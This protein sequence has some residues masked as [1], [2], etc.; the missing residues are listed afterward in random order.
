MGMF[1]MR[2]LEMPEDFRAGMNIHLQ[3]KQAW[4]FDERKAKIIINRS[5][6]TFTAYPRPGK[7]VSG[8]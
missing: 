4:Y 1:Y 3:D 2:I 5:G 6:P 8:G 7:I